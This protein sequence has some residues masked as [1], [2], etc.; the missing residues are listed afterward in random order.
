MPKIKGTRGRI[1]PEMLEGAKSMGAG[2]ATIASVGA[3]SVL[4]TCSV[5]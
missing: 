4:E 1:Y 3:V 2:A 5:F